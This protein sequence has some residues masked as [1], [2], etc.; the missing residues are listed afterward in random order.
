M[1]FNKFVIHVTNVSLF[2][3]AVAKIEKNSQERFAMNKFQE[4]NT[5]FP[6][7][8]LPPLIMEVEKK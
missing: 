3:D 4:K 2:Q 5:H 6:I 1:R 8:I 7:D